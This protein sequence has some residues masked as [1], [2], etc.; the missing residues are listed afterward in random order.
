MN[1][2]KG[3]SSFSNICKN[4]FKLKLRK[5]YQSDLKLRKTVNFTLCDIIDSCIERCLPEA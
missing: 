3:S 1:L 5:H 2:T 4:G